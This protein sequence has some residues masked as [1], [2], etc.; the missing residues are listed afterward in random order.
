MRVGREW[1]PHSFPPSAKN[2]T[3]HAIGNLRRA[4]ETK[5]FGTPRQPILKHFYLLHIILQRFRQL[6]V[7][8]LV[9]CLDRRLRVLEL[10]LDAVEI[11]QCGVGS[12]LHVSQVSAP[13]RAALADRPA[14]H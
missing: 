14:T 4:A 6:L 9:E 8:F 10:V 2:K 7:R 12:G 13:D 11:T 3:A 5:S 1:E